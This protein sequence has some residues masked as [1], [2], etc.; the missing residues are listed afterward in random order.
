MAFENP[1]YD[2]FFVPDKPE[3]A[4]AVKNTS[5]HDWLAQIEAGNDLSL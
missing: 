4:A 5:L 1:S 2:R 3:P